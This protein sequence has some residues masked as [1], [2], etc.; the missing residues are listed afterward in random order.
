MNAMPAV[1]QR[2]DADLTFSENS[3]PHWTHW[4]LLWTLLFSM[5]L[6]MPWANHR[7][8]DLLSRMLDLLSLVLQ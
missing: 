8:L 1:P 5:D 7:M 2:L 6:W 4:V 3:T